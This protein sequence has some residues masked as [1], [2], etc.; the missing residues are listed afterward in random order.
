MEDKNSGGAAGN[1]PRT[2]FRDEGG[3]PGACPWR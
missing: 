2:G 3:M 1:N